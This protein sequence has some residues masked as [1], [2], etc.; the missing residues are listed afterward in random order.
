MHG[1]VVKITSDN[2]LG[3]GLHHGSL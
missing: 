3:K 1:T 2:F